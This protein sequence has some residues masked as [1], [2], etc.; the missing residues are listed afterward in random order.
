MDLEEDLDGGEG[1]M[2]EL[3][4][5]VDR[6]GDGGLG[7]PSECFG[8]DAVNAIE[9]ESTIAPFIRNGSSRA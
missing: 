1:V 7:D 3:P 6:Y 8:Q 2:D 9:I 5:P 4:Y